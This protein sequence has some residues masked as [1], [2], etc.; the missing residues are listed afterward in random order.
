M[1]ISYGN[2]GID[3]SRWQGNIDWGTVAQST[4]IAIIKAS[5]AD[6]GF[7]TDSMFDINYNGAKSAGIRVGAYHFFTEYEDPIAQAEYFASLLN[8]KQWDIRPVIDVESGIGDSALTIK[9]LTF[10]ARVKEITGMDSIIYCSSNYAN[11]AFDNRITQYP[12]WIASYGVNEPDTGLWNEWVGFQYSSDEYL[13]GISDNTVDKDKFTDGIFIDNNYVAPIVNPQPIQQVNNDGTYVVQSGDTLS[14]IAS[15]FGTDYQTLANIN[16]IADVNLINVGQVL[17]VN[18]NTP[19][20]QPQSSGNTYVVQGGDTLSSIAERVGTS[21]QSL[22]QINGLSNPD[23]IN[24][25]QVLN[26]DSNVAPQPITQAPP[27]PEAVYYTVQEG[28]TLSGIA[29]NYGVSWQDLA[30][31]NGIADP[32]TIYIGQVI[33]IR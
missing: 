26:V 1:D 6:D 11:N 21:W 32:D 29:C 8:G 3:V 16:G 7:Y 23:L 24:V 5:G 13:N 33:R 19:I 25:G 4:N 2:F 12:V 9:V 31:F 30:N 10:C 17:N 22:A 18:I 14:S 27:Q 15:R 20:P 28:D